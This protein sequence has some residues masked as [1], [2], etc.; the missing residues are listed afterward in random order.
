MRPSARDK[1][2][3]MTKMTYRRAASDSSV[4]RSDANPTE[5]SSSDAA[6]V[7]MDLAVDVNPVAEEYISICRDINSDMAI[8]SARLQS[9][10]GSGDLTSINKI[11]GRVEDLSVFIKKYPELGES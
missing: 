2:N 3:P 7:A 4:G 10:D 6:L 8:I 5:P 1:L 11:S 9:S